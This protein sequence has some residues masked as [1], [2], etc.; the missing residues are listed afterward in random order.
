M[1]GY[2]YPETHGLSDY[3]SPARDMTPV[4]RSRQINQTDEDWLNLPGAG[5]T[6]C[7]QWMTVVGRQHLLAPAVS[8][9]PPRR[10]ILRCAYV[11]CP[12]DTVVQ[13]AEARV[14]K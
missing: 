8:R 1:Q 4:T 5:P 12:L 7:E 9:R 2:H 3:S 14:S 10:V 13:L 6:G 11:R